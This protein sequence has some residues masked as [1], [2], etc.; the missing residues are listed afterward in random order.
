MSLSLGDFQCSFYCTN[1]GSNGTRTGVQQ[2]VM[3]TWRRVVKRGK[4]PRKKTGAESCWKRTNTGT[5]VMLDKDKGFD[6]FKYFE[7]RV[8]NARKKRFS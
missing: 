2:G 8:W 5:C 3:G 4:V 6:C 7:K 1:P